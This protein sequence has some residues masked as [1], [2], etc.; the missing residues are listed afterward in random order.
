MQLVGRRYTQRP[1]C[2]V[3]IDDSRMP[4]RLQ[5]LLINPLFTLL[6]ML[7]PLSLIPANMSEHA[8]MASVVLLDA[9]SRVHDSSS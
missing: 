1:R 9:A 6:R 2:V 8:V 7:L 3:P 5:V 4:S